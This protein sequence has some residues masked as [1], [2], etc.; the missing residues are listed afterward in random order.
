MCLYGKIIYN[1]R[2]KPNK[3]NGGIIPAVSDRRV[4]GVPIGCGKCI[5]C[6]KQKGREW[7]L[8][9]TE[10]IKKYTNA[11]M[12]TLTFSNE[13]Y[14]EI[15]KLTNENWDAYTKDN[16]IATWAIRKFTERWR[17]KHK[18]T[19][20]HW[21]VTE[22]GHNGTENIHLHGLIWTCMGK[23]VIQKHWSYGFI[24]IG[25]YVNGSTINYI[26]KYCSK[27]DKDHRYYKPLI[28][29]SNGI[30]ANYTSSAR[31][32]ENRYN[33][34]NTREY[35]RTDSGH[36]MHLPNYWK[37]KIYSDDEKENLWIQKLDKEERW[38]CGEKI[39]LTKKG[40]EQLYYQTLEWHREKNKILGYGN[41]EINWSRK[42]YENERR[43]LIQNERLAPSAGSLAKG[44]GL[45]RRPPT[46]QDTSDLEGRNKHTVR[47]SG[48][49]PAVGCERLHQLADRLKIIWD[50]EN[51]IWKTE[52]NLLKLL[53]L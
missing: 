23:E 22:L 33:S 39:D 10:D 49:A 38:I 45:N 2:Y 11:K 46:T 16:F 48:V 37:N 3:K 1:P 12:V 35:Y 34:Q 25:E 52:N 50:E 5:E 7:Q 26:T 24:H 17:K 21:L 27:V 15:H 30:G 32:K 43:L 14:R 44:I 6:M 53:K 4:L 9:L 28:L 31:A 19:I 40:A 36:K 13:A 41:D 8:R 42:K 29:T 47:R 20:R 18:G 51:K